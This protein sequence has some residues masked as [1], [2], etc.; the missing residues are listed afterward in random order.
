MDTR[1]ALLAAA[2][3]EFARHG[4]KGTRIREIVARSG[5]NERMIYHH[6]G[7][8]EGLY[9]AV[10]EHEAAGVE[11]I[12]RSALEQAVSMDPYAG[13]RLVYRT[14]FD[15]MHARPLLISL[16]T[17]EAMGGWGV[18]P[19]V[20]ADG[21]PA[22]LRS[23]HARGVA[24]GIFRSDI[25]LDVFYVTMVSTLVAVPGMAGHFPSLLV[26]RDLAELRDQVITLLL[27]GITGEK[28]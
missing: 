13:I 25:D 23:L 26:D 10:F 12:W 22:E 20:T 21:I 9:R 1:A 14:Y 18:R 28:T 5:V 4:P 6:F 27:D 2:A 15:M 17:Q 8:K 24:E 19:Q 11:A 16:V 7:S 3:E